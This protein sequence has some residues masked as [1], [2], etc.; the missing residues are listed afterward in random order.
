MP[1]RCVK[2]DA[3]AQ[4]SYNPQWYYMLPNN[5]DRNVTNPNPPTRSDK[6]TFIGEDGNLKLS[7]NP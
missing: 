5:V 3:P 1:V 7:L 2:G 4:I 6:A